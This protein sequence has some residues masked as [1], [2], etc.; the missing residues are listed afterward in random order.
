MESLEDKQIKMRKPEVVHALSLSIASQVL[1]VAALK[2][3]VHSSFRSQ[4]LLPRPLQ[5]YIILHLAV[6]VVTRIGPI[7]DQK[8]HGEVKSESEE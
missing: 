8:R 2:N 1:I 6:I 3:M 7:A 5:R 4:K